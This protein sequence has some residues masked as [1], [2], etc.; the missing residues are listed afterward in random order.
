MSFGLEAIVHLLEQRRW[1]PEVSN[2]GAFFYPSDQ[3]F[4]AVFFP[5]KRQGF[6][7]VLS[8]S[9]PLISVPK[10]PKLA[11]FILEFRGYPGLNIEL[12]DAGAGFVNLVCY[13][14]FPAQ[15]LDVEEIDDLF[16]ALFPGARSL[17]DE[18]IGRFGGKWKSEDN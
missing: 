10:S 12:E 17:A 5:A 2:G 1:K 18:V 16:V 15:N 14:S 11:R 7:W 3:D 6:D 13:A 9:F 4:H 8:A